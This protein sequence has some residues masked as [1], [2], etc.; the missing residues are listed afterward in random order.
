M[1]VAASPA[2]SSGFVPPDDEDALVDALVTAASEPEERRARC[3]RAHAESRR[4]AW[5]MIAR[6]FAALYEELLVSPQES[7]TEAREG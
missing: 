5:P 4:Y 3:E 1:R 6:R 7:Q 2:S